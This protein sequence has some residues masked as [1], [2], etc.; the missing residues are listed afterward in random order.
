M[1]IYDVDTDGG[2]SYSSM[3]AA[4]SA[5]P[6]TFSSDNTI[7][8]TG[9]TVDNTNV[10]I[11]VNTAGFNLYIVPAAGNEHILDWNASIY[12]LA[13][14]NNTGGVIIVSSDNVVIRG[15][16]IRNTSGAS[17]ARGIQVIGTGCII[18]GNLI[19]ASNTNVA[20]NAIDITGLS[21]GDNVYIVN[22]A[23]FGYWTAGIFG[24]YSNPL[25][26]IIAYN[27]TIDGANIDK[28]IDL[29]A[30]STNVSIYLKNNIVQ[31]CT[32]A[33]YEITGT[34][35]LTSANNISSD[36]SSPDTSYRSLTVTFQTGT[37]L[38]DA[39]DTS[40]LD[41]GV[42][43]SADAAY[44]FSTDALGTTRPSGSAW[45][46]GAHELIQSSG[47]TGTGSFTSTQVALSGSAVLEHT[48]LGSLS[49]ASAT[50]SG[51]AKKEFSASGGIQ[52]S[53]PTI[54]GTGTLSS[55][56]T[57]S[58]NLPTSQVELSGSAVIDHTG[59][60][61][62]S[63]S[64][65]ALSGSGKRELIASG[66][67]QV[68]APTISGTGLQSAP[69]TITGSGNLSAGNAAI[70]GAATL[71]HTASVTLSIVN[72]EIAGSAVLEHSATGG[73][74]AP[75]S[76]L[77]GTATIPVEITCTGSFVAPVIQLSGRQQEEAKQ[78]Y[79]GGFYFWLKYEQEMER[80]KAERRERQ[81]LIEAAEEAADE[82]ENALIEESRKEYSEQERKKELERLTDIADKYRKDIKKLPDSV[83]ISFNRA[84]EKRTF[85]AMEALERE[86]AR[87][88]EEEDFL[89]EATYLM[90]G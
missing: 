38:L 1:A 71:E 21:S 68:T 72:A 26:D 50:L 45:D 35:S 16:Q 80:R 47:V 76:E 53:I 82:I 9:S 81:R 39:A 22:N 56:K 23:I 32:T 63:V 33:D 55:G 65:I 69:G 19:E 13:A 24:N 36:T 11:S 88:K 3:S 51:S 8:C 15:M 58:G 40:A 2:G 59:S 5:L 83:I 54:S 86:L 29:N 28:G 90:V 37:Y 73:M 4:V 20:G 52:A 61:A 66:V 87:V 34:Y 18:D 12:R 31:S 49:V 41:A 46:I 48:V 17:S 84:I 43:L 27:N 74:S 25:L 10:S 89:I 30:G 64:S 57:G 67:F 7:T 14:L 6:A 77:S 79:S 85:S 70:S 60:G 78:E 42:T 62:F 44:Q 75:V